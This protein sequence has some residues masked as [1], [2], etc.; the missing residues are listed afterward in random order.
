MPNLRLLSWP[1]RLIWLGLVLVG[2]SA[3]A[4]LVSVGFRVGDLAGLLAPGQMSLGIAASSLAALLGI[5]VFITGLVAWVLYCSATPERARR[6]Y[7]SLWTILSILGVAV[8]VN[9]ILIIPVLYTQA[10]P[11][12]GENLV[13]SPGSL[14]LALITLDGPLI[15]LLYLRIVR[16]RVLSWT[17][18]GFTTEKFWQRIGLGLLVSVVAIGAS[19]MVQEALLRVGIESTQM[20]MF[21]GVR[22]ATIPQF[23]GVLLAGSVIAP[24]CEETFF[25]GY[26]FT[27]IKRAR[28]APIGIITSSVLFALSHGNLTIFLPI[29]LVGAIFAVVFG[30]TGS[31]VPSIVAHSVLNAAGFLALYLQPP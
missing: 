29:L 8:I 5:L 13:L 18:M 4:G 11:S 25:R 31:L 17:E 21:A 1:A 2:A 20:D 15:G 22:D 27:A 19:A 10:L 26:V 28:G 7:G 14:V 23:I 16:F 30:R 9:T 6:G 24:V 3:V 12:P